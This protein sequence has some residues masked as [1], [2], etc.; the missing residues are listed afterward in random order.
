MAETYISF[1]ITTFFLHLVE[2]VEIIK[3]DDAFSACIFDHV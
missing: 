1:L 2:C 3:N